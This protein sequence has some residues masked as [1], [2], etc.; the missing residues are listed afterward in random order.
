MNSL[1]LWMSTQFR[2]ERAI[3]NELHEAGIISD[4]CVWARD[5]ANGDADKAVAWLKDN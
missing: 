2:T 1:E 3:M 5:V 4:N